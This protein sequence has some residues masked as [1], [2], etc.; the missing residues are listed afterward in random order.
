MKFLVIGESCRDVFI[1]G[2]CT[3]LAPEA[4]APV[5]N[6]ISSTSNGGMAMNVFK[7]MQS[8][9]TD[10]HIQTNH[11]WEDVTKTRY[12]HQN[13]NHMFL[14]VDQN[15]KIKRIDNLKKINFGKY[16]AIIISDYN[17]GYLLEDD[18]KYITENHD[19]VFLDTKKILN[20]SWC[21]N[22]RYIKIN[23]DEYKKTKYSIGDTLTKKIIVTMGPEGCMFQGKMYE[24]PKVEIKDSSGAGDTFLSAFVIKF[25]ETN[26]VNDALVFANR[27]AT[28]VVQM[29]GVVCVKEGQ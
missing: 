19:N 14:R 15:D 10:C 9:G 25:A 18:I 4:P 7:N 16:A 12:V 28:Q 13:H 29:R 6:P 1:Y 3:R 11:N 22:I 5:F 26:R 27:C 24:V 2:N 20:E 21:S 17:K 23:N 8:L